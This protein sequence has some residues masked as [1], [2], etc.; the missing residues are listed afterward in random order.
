LLDWTESPLVAA[1]F[2]VLD[3]P[4]DDGCIW[5]LSPGGLNATRDGSHG[6]VQIKDP[7]IVKIAESAFN[8]ISTERTIIAIDGQEIDPRMLAQLSRFTL[9]SEPDPLELMPAS[10]KWL[11]QYIIPKNAKAN[12]REQLKAFGIRRSNIF[13][14]LASLATELR[15]EFW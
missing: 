8:N 1:Y 10:H 9:H 7:S 12:M 2:A 3:C 4:D 5:G 13:P 14:D 15:S 11:R 6:F